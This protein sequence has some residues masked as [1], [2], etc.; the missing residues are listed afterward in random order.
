MALSYIGKISAT[1]CILLSMAIPASADANKG[2]TLFLSMKC[3]KCHAT[4]NN[5]KGPSLG[6]I[7]DTYGDESSLL[8]FFEGK[9]EPIVEPARAKT[10]KPRRRKLQKLSEEDQ[11]ALAAY[12]ITFKTVSIH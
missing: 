9:S 1:L 8:L 5:P 3:N 12:I 10:M 4:K 7:A 11:K 2:E 6:R